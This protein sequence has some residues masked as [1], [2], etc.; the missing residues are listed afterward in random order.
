MK[1]EAVRILTYPPEFK[2]TRSLQQFLLQRVQ[3]VLAAKRLARETGHP[4]MCR[5]RPH[6]RPDA[7]SDTPANHAVLYDSQGR[8]MV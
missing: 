3:L 6:E 4:S 8:L 5:E 1:D 2:G 7:S